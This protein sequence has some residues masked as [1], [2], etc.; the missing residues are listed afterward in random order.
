[1]T[2]CSASSLMKS[3]SRQASKTFS[4]RC[5]GALVEDGRVR[6]IIIENK[7]VATRFSRLSIID[8]T[9]DGDVAASAGAP[10]DQWEKNALTPSP[11]VLT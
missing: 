10:F 6:G 3:P 11:S 1:M 8:A 5:V 2:S 4:T 7:E 9:G